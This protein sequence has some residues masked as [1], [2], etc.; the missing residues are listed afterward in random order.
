[1]MAAFAVGLAFAAGVVADH[2][3]ADGDGWGLRPVVDA[4]RHGMRNR[5]YHRQD[6]DRPGRGYCD[7]ECQCNRDPRNTRWDSETNSCHIL[8]STGSPDGSRG[9][10]SGY[11]HDQGGYGSHC[12]AGQGRGFAP[13]GAF[14][15]DGPGSFWE[16]ML[17]RERD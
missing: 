5:P 1:M 4:Q 17:W 12:D 6:D 10:C 8:W 16:W 9:S 7:A 3:D 13:P 11:P 14:G 2:V 15:D